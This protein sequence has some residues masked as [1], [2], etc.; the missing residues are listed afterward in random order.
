MS[1]IIKV[2]IPIRPL[3]K[4]R[5]RT[6]KRGGK[7][8]TFTPPRTRKYEADVAM[9]MKSAMVGKE[10]LSGQVCVSA[11]FTKDGAEIKFWGTGS[12]AESK[13]RGDL[14]NYLKA[15]LDAANGI[16]FHDDKQVERITL[17]KS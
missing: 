9:I 11:S 16:I 5:P 3:A 12:Q 1:D 8:V 4:E 15:V 6:F 10:K 2:S 7:S 13:L 17:E 14:D